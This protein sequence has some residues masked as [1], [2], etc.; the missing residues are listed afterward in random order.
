LD[1]F[2][3]YVFLQNAQNHYSNQMKQILTPVV[4]QF[5]FDRQ[6]PQFNFQKPVGTPTR[7]HKQRCAPPA[8]GNQTNVE[9]DQ[10]LDQPVEKKPVI[11]NC[12]TAKSGSGKNGRQPVQVIEQESELSKVRYDIDPK[13]SR[14]V[15]VN[16]LGVL[17]DYMAS[18]NLN[19]CVS[20]L[21]RKQS[22]AAFDQHATALANASK[23]S[24]VNRIAAERNIKAG[25]RDVPRVII[26]HRIKGTKLA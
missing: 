26:R 19:E 6:M 22:K 24:D 5:S 8:S 4:N 23:G 15:L 10:I 25:K 17:N 1:I 2:S 11:T 20:A 14:A 21:L 18:E 16:G 3:P 7:E 13:N 12:K 9:C